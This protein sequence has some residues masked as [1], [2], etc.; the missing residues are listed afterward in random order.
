MSDLMIWQYRGKPKARATISAIQFETD[1]A[2]LSA[3]EFGQML[4][5][6]TATG[7]ALDLVGR[8]VG[9]TRLIKQYIAK[10]FFGFQGDA[11][12]QGVNGHLKVHH[13]GHLKVHHFKSGF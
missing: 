6:D 5:I 11:N 3:V 4:N 10:N 12:A 7:F 8:H 1:R 13:Y 2:F 9:V